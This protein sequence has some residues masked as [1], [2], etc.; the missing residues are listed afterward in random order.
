MYTGE[1]TRRGPAVEFAELF[2]ASKKGSGDIKR[3]N[4]PLAPHG[5][6]AKAMKCYLGGGWSVCTETAVFD[7]KVSVRVLI[8]WEYHSAFSTQ[9]LFTGSRSTFVGMYKS[10]TSVEDALGEEE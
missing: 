10:C 6:T 5:V 1:S 3:A 4:F 2:V 9:I 7:W 8:S